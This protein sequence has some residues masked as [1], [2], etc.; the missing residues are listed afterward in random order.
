M[1]HSPRRSVRAP[2]AI[3]AALLLLL[4]SQNGQTQGNPPGLNYFK[5]FFVTG[6]YVAASVDFGSVSGGAG[7]IQADINFDDP[8]ELVPSNA[9]VVGAFLYWQTIVD[10]SPM[11]LSGLE[12]RGEDISD[13]AK[14][15]A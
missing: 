3:F 12:F 15:V 7:F 8:E 5:N 6:N 9:D 1:S 4:S 2:G 10:A 14:E 13:I 11:P